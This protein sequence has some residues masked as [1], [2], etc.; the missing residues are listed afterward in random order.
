MDG[1]DSI[2]I[3]VVY[4]SLWHCFTNMNLKTN[5]TIPKLRRESLADFQD[6]SFLDPQWIW[7]IRSTR[8]EP[9][10]DHRS[11]FPGRIWKDLKSKIFQQTADMT[12]W[13]FR[14]R[15]FKMFQEPLATFATLVSRF[16]PI[17][18]A[19]S[20]YWDR[21]TR[22][23]ACSKSWAIDRA[24]SAPAGHSRTIKSIGVS[25]WFTSI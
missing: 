1:I 2:K 3:C 23:F 5:W 21:V 12:K 17:V 15:M 4:S 14:L 25:R 6:H 9:T 20:A 7:R 22:S 16:C 13:Q 18:L 24:S 10:P 11:N 8:K 19:C